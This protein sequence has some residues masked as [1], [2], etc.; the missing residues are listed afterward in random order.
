MI[1]VILFS[2]ILFIVL[3]LIKTLSSKTSNSSAINNTHRENSISVP[4]SL[5]ETT[6]NRTIDR[7]NNNN[8]AWYNTKYNSFAPQNSSKISPLVK[9]NLVKNTTIRK[10][11]KKL[12]YKNANA[13]S[14]RHNTILIPYVNYNTGQVNINASKMRPYPKESSNPQR[15]TAMTTDEALAF[16]KKRR[17][18][19]G[20]TGTNAH[21]TASKH[22]AVNEN[23]ISTKDLIKE[24]KKNN[25]RTGRTDF[26]HNTGKPYDRNRTV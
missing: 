7:D 2:V 9:P 22:A 12:A 26:N 25:A 24:F 15:R 6:Y 19:M 20:F 1:Y 16:D 21:V 18:M 3:I 10:P 5:F 4:N 17:E 14:P 11:K 8:T 23:V 13:I